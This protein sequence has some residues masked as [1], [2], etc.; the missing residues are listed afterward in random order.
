MFTTSIKAVGEEVRLN[1]ERE[2]MAQGTLIQKDK[3]ET[4]TNHSS[5]GNDFI[6]PMQKRNG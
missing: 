3:L 5:Q 2:L 1:E 4:S 6:S